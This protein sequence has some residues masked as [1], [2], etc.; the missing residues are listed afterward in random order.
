MAFFDGETHLELL[1]LDDEQLD[2]PELADVHWGSVNLMLTDW[3]AAKELGDERSAREL[4]LRSGNQKTA[5]DIVR[6]FQAAV[7]ANRQFAAALRSQGMAEDADRFAYRG[8]V[9]QRHVLLRRR[10]WPRYLGSVLLDLISGHGYRPLRS[11]ALYTCVVVG[12]ATLYFLMR[13]SVHPAL[14]PLDSVIFSITSFHG[15]GFSPGE[16]VTLHNPL[17]IVAAVEAII[18][19]LIEITFIATFTQRFFAR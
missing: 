15:R 16:N 4:R 17:T 12:F 6:G 13:D 19:L 5:D 7:R 8:L 9:L 3:S 2:C 14:N 11:V 10:R 18:G 1:V